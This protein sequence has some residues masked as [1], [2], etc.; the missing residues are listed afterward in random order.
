M[1]FDFLIE[2]KFHACPIKCHAYNFC[3]TVGTADFVSDLLSFLNR[4]L[5]TNCRGI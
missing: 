4:L 2:S 1:L 5:E 3:D